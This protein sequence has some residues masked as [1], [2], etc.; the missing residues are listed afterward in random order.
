MQVHAKHPL[1]VVYAIALHYV[2]AITLLLDGK[3]AAV[4]ATS[5]LYGRFDLVVP[6]FLIFAATFALWSL[7]LPRNTLWPILLILPQQFALSLSAYTAVSAMISGRFADGT[8]RPAAF[9]TADQC[10]AVLIMLFH[11]IAILSDYVG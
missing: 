11:T 6:Y 5:G 10:P 7:F 1:V 3:A 2:W 9:I 4:T 8:V